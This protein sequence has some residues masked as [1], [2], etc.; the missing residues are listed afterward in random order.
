M[1]RL[2]EIQKPTVVGAAPEG[3]SDA[4]AAARVVREMFTT[5]AP[6]YDLLNHVLSFNVDR[7]WWWR[8][9]RTFAHLISQPDSRILDLCCGTGDMTFALRKQAGSNRPQIVGADFSHAMLQRARSKSLGKLQENG[10]PAAPRWIEADAL[11]LPFPSQH[12]SLV[13]S[14]FGF[15]NLADYD[16]GLREIVRVLKPGGE[17]GILDFSEPKGLMGHLYRIYFKQVLPRVGAMISG[18]RGPYEYLPDSVERFPQPDEMLDRMRRAG[19]REAKWTPYTFGI[20]GLYRG[21]K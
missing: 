3:A 17:C 18:V 5:I 16:A 15:R 1:S 14:A 10:N 2:A 8:T 19:F 12:F 21:K 13:T 20:A 7:L 4:A 11:C 9:A 6:R